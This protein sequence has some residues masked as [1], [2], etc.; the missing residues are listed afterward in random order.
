VLKQVKV[1]AKK[2]PV[3]SV[4]GAGTRAKSGQA[5]AKSPGI[6]KQ[7]LL[8]SLGSFTGNIPEL[9]ARYVARP[10]GS[11]APRFFVSPFAESPAQPAGQPS[12]LPL[13]AAETD[14]AGCDCQGK[15]KQ[16]QPRKARS[17]CYSGRFIERSHGLQ[18]TRQRKV[19]CRQSRK[20][21]A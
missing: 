17:V 2:I 4:P 19:P 20:K 12:P 11:S 21:R 18:K 13:T 14:Q 6:F 1:T 3:P 16:T 15:K 10:R 7:A 8:R 5:V 9:F